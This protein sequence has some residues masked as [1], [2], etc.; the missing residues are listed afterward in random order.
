MV[1][2][3]KAPREQVH[4][5]AAAG[6]RGGSH[7]EA[8]RRPLPRG[9]NLAIQHNTVQHFWLSLTLLAGT[10]IPVTYL[11]G[12]VPHERDHSCTRASAAM[13]DMKTDCDDYVDQS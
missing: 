11:P 10:H 12:G 1:Q 9:Q 7:R 13:S 8:H 4:R 6:E 5:P 3:A 2:M